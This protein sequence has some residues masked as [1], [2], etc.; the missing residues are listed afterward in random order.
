MIEF[1]AR[2]TLQALPAEMAHDLAIKALGGPLS[3]F[4]RAKQIQH[5]VELMGIRFPNPV[6][7]AAG[8]DKNGDALHGLS[9]QGFGFLEIGTITPKPQAGNDKPRL[10]RLAADEAIINRMGFNN[11]GIDHLVQ[12]VKHS[13]YQGVLGINIGK[14]K[15]TPNERA[16][17][18]YVHCFAKAHTLCDYITVNISS[19]NTPDLRELQNDQAFVDLLSGIKAKQ[20]ACAEIDQKYTPV[21]VKISPD[22]NHEQLQFMVQQI[23]DIGFDGIIC[24]NTTIDRPNTLHSDAEL[25]Q[26]AGGLSGKPLLEKSNQ[27]LKWV[28]QC[29]GKNFPIF[30]VGGII[31]KEDARQ[32][33]ELGADLIQVYTGFVLKGN[34][35]IK[36]INQQLTSE[37]K[38]RP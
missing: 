9:K 7:L 35:L 34:H 26:Q 25:I 11:K 36:Q 16:V 20:L 15:T 28:R 21:V 38:T 6:G 12:R 32:K 30:A 31:D 13:G 27:T 23:K 4:T 22:Q 37:N 14:N 18:D 8:F 5:P 2:K 24:T 10:F 33:F 29:A 19:P 17:D 1:F 3:A